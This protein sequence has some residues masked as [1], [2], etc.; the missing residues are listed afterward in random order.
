[1]QA[2]GG[3]RQVKAAVLYEPGT[4]F[5]V[6][7][8]TLDD[9]GPGEALVRLVASGVCHSDWHVVAGTTQHPMP[10]V[11]GHEGAGVVEAVGDGVT[12][13]APGDHVILNWAPDCGSCFYCL[14][15]RPNLCEAF[16]GPMWAGTMLD[17]SIRLRLDGAPIHHFSLVSS[18]AE[19]AVVPEETCVPIRK[20]VPLKAASLVGCGVTTGLGATMYTVQVRPGDKVAVF[21][22]GGVGLNILQGA[23]LCGAET[24][25]AVD[26]VPAKMDMARA[27]GATHSVL[28]DATAIEAIKDLTRGRGA[29]YAFEAVGAPAVQE[30]ALDAIR[31][32]GTLVLVGLA[33]MGSVT[34]LPG[35]V[36][37]RE[38]KSVVGSYYGSANTRRD[39]PMMLDL[40]IAGKIK[41]DE[42]ISREYTL[43]G[44]N[45]A[46]AALL[47]GEVARSVI[48]FD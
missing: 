38:E 16:V 41:L 42:L 27:F 18:F 44:I 19:Q 24:I 32:G 25:I 46:Y 33:P 13:V 48:V 23:A 26:Q 20:D 45:Q 1:M 47:S 4:A 15:G 5:V 21:G 12:R 39:F 31:P 7:T 14:R 9:P 36:L 29:D 43:D 6:E 17:G 22:C 40:Y 30:L 34:N 28:A 2:M 35:A 37:T 3:D 8:L 10:L 11:L